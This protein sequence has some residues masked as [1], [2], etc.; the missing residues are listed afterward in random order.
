MMAKQN[1]M[2]MSFFPDHYK[3]KLNEHPQ[4]IKK[5]IMRHADKAMASAVRIA[6]SHKEHSTNLPSNPEI[7]CANWDAAEAWANETFLDT[8]ILKFASR[9]FRREKSLIGN[10]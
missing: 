1:K 6:I 4:C 7:S 5:S 2:R 9:T 3:G 8:K 10:V